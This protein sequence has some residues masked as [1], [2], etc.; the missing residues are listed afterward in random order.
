LLLGL[1]V[2]I[3]ETKIATQL[4]YRADNDC[5]GLDDRPADGL[6]KMS[7]LEIKNLIELGTFFIGGDSQDVC[8][9]SD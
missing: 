7:E 5:C 4:A 2:S 9:F 3:D 6:D 8:V 1:S